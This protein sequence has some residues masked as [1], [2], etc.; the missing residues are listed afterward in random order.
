MERVDTLLNS[1]YISRRRRNSYD[2]GYQ[3]TLNEKRIS[4]IQ[5]NI[6]N[7]NGLAFPNSILIYSP[8][9]SDNIIPKEECPKSTTTRFPTSFCSC[10]VIDGQHRLLGFSKLDQEN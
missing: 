7:Q 2:P 5:Q 8:K 1:C 9:L 10:R 3:R 4:N 6:E